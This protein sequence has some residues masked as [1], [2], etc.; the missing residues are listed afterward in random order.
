MSRWM[1]S[2]YYGR[3]IASRPARTAAGHFRIV[4]G[5]LV[6]SLLALH[7]IYLLFLSP[8]VSWPLV[9]LLLASMAFY[10]VYV[11]VRMH[12]P[13]M[14]EARY[15]T[16]RIQM[17]RAQSGILGTTLLLVSFSYL[18]QPNVF[19]PLLLLPIMI[20]SEHC[21]TNTLLGVL[22][23]VML[24]MLGVAWLGSHQPLPIFMRSISAFEGLARGLIMVLLGFPL[25]YTMRNLDARD[26]MIDRLRDLLKS[27]SQ[28]LLAQ[29]EPKTIRQVGLKLFVEMVGAQCGELWVA[30]RQPDVLYL[31]ASSWESD[32]QAEI[33]CLTSS[34]GPVS[35][36]LD[37]DGENLPSRVMHTGEPHCISWSGDM[38]AA[39]AQVAL[40]CSP[41]L[42]GAA[43]EFGVPVRVF[44]LQKPE[45]V[46]VLILSFFRPM[47]KEELRRVFSTAVEMADVLSPLFY[48]ASLTAE[49]LAL[50]DMSYIVSH[51]VERRPVIDAVLDVVTETLG[52]D[53]AIVSL[54][55]EVKQTIAAFEGRN[56]DQAWLDKCVHSLD[57]YDI[58]VDVIHT[59]KS[60]VL[61]SNCFTR[62]ARWTGITHCPYGWA[63]A[64]SWTGSLNGAS[65]STPVT[66]K[67][68]PL[69]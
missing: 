16:S 14:W 33:A 24:I 40:D 38:P 51:N 67:I 8:I 43:V 34:G 62:L 19:W 53:F 47:G 15:Y 11:V 31:A 35:T 37:D 22:A 68:M 10:L 12:I 48:F 26:E 2:F 66:L 41:V 18:G 52:F 60:E 65:L 29:R 1:S 7:L 5:V 61:A 42:A 25:H 59:G 17:I 9:G 57:S 54:V 58:Q 44:Q 45:S 69:W 55:D 13:A 30:G 56:V 49:L 3:P 46:A 23:E 63:K 20:V 28:H 50:R 6:L 4:V 39:L 64:T 27:M 32:A 36:V 21:S